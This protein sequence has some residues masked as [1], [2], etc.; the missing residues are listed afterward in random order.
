MSEGENGSPD[1]AP[2]LSVLLNEK[3]LIYLLK[4][5][6]KYRYVFILQ[7]NVKTALIKISFN[8]IMP[9]YTAEVI[10]WKCKPNIK[11]VYHSSPIDLL[12]KLIK[13][14]K[15]PPFIKLT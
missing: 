15:F 3:M 12:K 2:K 7:G 5:L 8:L 6:H 9:T 14:V 4:N 10:T 13:N 1:T 11:A